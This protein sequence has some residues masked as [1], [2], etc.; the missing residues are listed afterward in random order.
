MMMME[1]RI[2]YKALLSRRARDLFI[3]TSASPHFNSS[4]YY[5]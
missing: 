2:I 5:F 1:V 3:E 4:Y